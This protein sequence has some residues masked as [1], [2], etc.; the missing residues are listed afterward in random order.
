MKRAFH[1]C[2]TRG[3]MVQ[4]YQCPHIFLSATDHGTTT[5]GGQGAP[6]FRRYGPQLVSK[7]AIRFRYRKVGGA[8]VER[9]IGSKYFYYCAGPDLD[10]LAGM[11]HALHS[12]C[13]THTPVVPVF[14]PDS[15]VVPSLCTWY[16]GVTPGSTQ[17]LAFLACGS[18]E[19]TLP[20]LRRDQRNTG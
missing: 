8:T 1:G 17:P 20:G 16:G 14:Q 3:R 2:S 18:A 15:G 7:P 5:S 6:F 12:S 19:D 4:V 10:M 13:K 11:F 9:V